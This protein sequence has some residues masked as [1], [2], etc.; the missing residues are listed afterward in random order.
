MTFHLVAIPGVLALLCAWSLAATVL[1][2][3]HGAE[4]DAIEQD[5]SRETA[6]V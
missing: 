6:T 4:Q 2:T 5:V 3:G 1:L